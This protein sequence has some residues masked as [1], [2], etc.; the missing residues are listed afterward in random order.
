MTIT[1]YLRAKN[2]TGYLRVRVSEGRGKVYYAKTNIQIMADWWDPKREQLKSKAIIRPDVRKEISESIESLRERILT[3]Y[4][5]SSPLQDGSTWLAGVV[6]GKKTTDDFH[7]LFQSFYE[8]RDIGNGRRKTYRCLHG[9][10]IRFERIKGVKL[11]VDMK[12]DVFNSLVDFI[13]N[14]HSYVALHP[15]IYNG[16][17]VNERT[18][19]YLSMNIKM[20]KAFFNYL[21]KTEQI[22]KMPRMD[23][24]TEVYGDP[25]ALTAEEVDAIYHT[26]IPRALEKYRD[27]FVLHCHLGLRV[28]DF[29]SL[30][31]EDIQDGVLTYIP[32]KTSKQFQTI[33]RVPLSSV[34]LEIIERYECEDGRIFPFMNVN[35]VNGYNKRIKAVLEACGVVRLVPHID[36]NTGKRNY[37]RVCDVASSHTARKTFVSCVLNA[38]KSDVITASM[39]GHRDMKVFRRY[40]DIKTE[41]LK[42]VIVKTF[43]GE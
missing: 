30:R 28:S 1:F 7:S 29:V 5:E 34:A 11:T 36:S 22:E 12:Q 39:T 41:T 32:A 38:T 21:M 14:E 33:V 31:K 27:M 24:P 16:L 6:T 40:S 19:N 26:T 37:V 42:D 4:H 17:P 43:G 10:L 2:D 23:P 8:N 15:E 35:G 9:K 20:L 18:T 13:K 3:S 25:I